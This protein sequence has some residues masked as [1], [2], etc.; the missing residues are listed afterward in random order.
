MTQYADFEIGLHRRDAVN[1]AVEM[2][3]NLPGD[4]ADNRETAEAQFDTDGL[5]AVSQDPAAYGQ[6]L[7]ECLFADPLAQVALARAKEAIQRQ[8]PPMGLRLQLMIGPSAP[9]LYAF[10]WETLRLPGSS[11]PVSTGENILFSRYLTSRDWTQV[12][13]RSKSELK[14]LVIV[15][16]PSNLSKYQLAEVKVQEE[17]DHAKEN[18]GDIPVT[19]IPGD[20]G[21]KATL[22]NLLGCMRISVPDILY[23]V[24]HG[25]LKQAEPLVLLED[26]TG[27]AQFV[28]GTDLVARMADL[29]EHPR[30]VVL[31]SCQSAVA[32]KGG[33]LSALGPRMAEAGIPAV[34]AMQGDVSMA[35]AARLM[36]V[37]FHEL[38]QDGQIDRALAAARGSVLA[39]DPNCTDF[40]M[41]VLFSRLKNGQVWYVPRM[42]SSVG[43]DAW[44]TL[45]NAIQEKRCTPVLGP[46]VMESWLGQPG[47]IARRW[48]M[49]YRYPLAPDEFDQLPRVAQYISRKESPTELQSEYNRS[50][51]EEIT[52]RYEAHVPEDLAEAEFW[53]SS[54]VLKA[55][56]SAAGQLWNAPATQVHRWLADLKLPIYVTTCTDD[57]LAQALK[58]RG[59]NPVV[60]LCP[61]WGPTDQDELEA[62][63]LYDD[64]PTTD[65]PLVYHLY[66]HLNTPDSLVLSEDNYFDFLIGYIRYKNNIPPIIR[67][68]LMN[69]SLLF[70]GFRTDD[71]SYRVLFR[72]LINQKGAAQFLKNR[73]VN[74]QVEPEEGRL[75]DTQRALRY[76][77]EVFTKDNIATYWGRSEDFLHDLTA[78]VNS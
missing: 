33:V 42:S 74:A 62:K 57:L 19:T 73:H 23:L 29:P 61:W 39:A 17:I 35:T 9:E 65:N 6:K 21:S 59:A 53:K 78:K 1:Y 46:G 70:I 16:N 75:Y 69:S 58:Q 66:G 64:E 25:M 56:N 40:W 13:L 8:D 22:N 47:E 44:E 68:T 4:D 71:W 67:D 20:G 50:L 12:R 41:P 11:S 60:R 76:L 34:L 31:L 30:L 24:C 37:F 38:R 49:K 55:L 7:S 26:E 36:P 77:E 3:F 32:G 2:R 15:A 10:H 51:R 43:F 54:Q 52:K 28:S 45:K 27:E 48:A 14:A 5:L 18:L 72:T 63:C